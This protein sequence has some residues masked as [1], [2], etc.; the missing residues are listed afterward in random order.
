VMEYKG[1]S[2]LRQ[3]SRPPTKYWSRC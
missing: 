1:N 3:E 2:S